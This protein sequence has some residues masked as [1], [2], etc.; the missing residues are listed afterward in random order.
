[1]RPIQRVH[2]IEYN[3]KVNTLG[4]GMVFPKYGT[5]LLAAVLRDRGYDV[6]IFLEGVSDMS[7]E[8]LIDCDALCFPY[9]RPR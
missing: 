5:P 8:K 3:A 9:L 1:M 2:F 7:F 4:M 6:S